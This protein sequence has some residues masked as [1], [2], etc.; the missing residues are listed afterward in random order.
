MREI[1]QTDLPIKP[2][3]QDK[4]RRLPGLNPI[5]EGD[6][7]RVDEVYAEQMAYRR[8]LLTKKR[9]DVFRMS[10]QAGRAATELLER[11]L[12]EL[13]GVD[14]FQRHGDSVL[15]PDGF[16]VEIDWNEPLLSAANLVQEDLVLMQKAGEEHALTAA[17]LCFPASWSLDEK[18]GG[19]LLKIHKP[20]DPYTDD[21]GMRVQRLFDFIKPEHPMWRANFLI[22]SNPDLFQPRREDNRRVIDREAEL[23]VRVER[24]CLVKLPL[25]QAVVFS[26]HS[27]VVPITVLSEHEIAELNRWNDHEHKAF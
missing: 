21:I 14:G 24:Q 1:C 15:C 11:I 2:W 19:G 20:V 3:M 23:W 8:D 18:F 26:I 4:T 6:W 17:V 25:S 10:D 7:L 5:A 12:Q 16:R 22:Y 13:E 27:Y 9:H